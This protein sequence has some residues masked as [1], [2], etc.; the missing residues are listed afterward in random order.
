MTWV[1]VFVG[2]RGQSEKVFAFGGD[3][4]EDEN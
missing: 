2:E 3:N 1:V 4:V